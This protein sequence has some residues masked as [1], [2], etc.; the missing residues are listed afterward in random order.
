[1]KFAPS[2]CL[3]ILRAGVRLL[4]RAVTYNHTPQMAA[5]LRVFAAAG[6]RLC[7]ERERDERAEWAERPAEPEVPV[8]V[9]EDYWTYE[10]SKDFLARRPADTKGDPMT[11]PAMS[12]IGQLMV[13][14]EAPA[15]G[16]VSKPRRRLTG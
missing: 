15:A 5:P 7:R 16:R 12:T 6:R 10:Q 13:E 8:R 1:M 14:I 11:E 3:R 4:E 9:P 2:D